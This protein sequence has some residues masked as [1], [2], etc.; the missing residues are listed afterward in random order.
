MQVDKILMDYKDLETLKIKMKS[1]KV[2]VKKLKAEK[3]FMENEELNF[4]MNEA[5]MEKAIER[6]GKEKAELEIKL[7]KFASNQTKGKAG[8]LVKRKRI[9]RGKYREIIRQNCETKSIREIH[10][11]CVRE[12]FTGIY[13]TMRLSVLD[14]EIEQFM[15]QEMTSLQIQKALKIRRPK[16]KMEVKTIEEMMENL[17]LRKEI[18]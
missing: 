12:G 14:F 6:L 9:A 11:M 3:E 18:K 16:T 7:D 2:E 10:K 15:K 1:L 17:K 13:E 8:N 4:K 5:K